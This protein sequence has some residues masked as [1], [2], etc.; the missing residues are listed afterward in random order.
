MFKFLFLMI[1]KF[2]KLKTLFAALDAST[3]LSHGE[4][5]WVGGTK[6]VVQGQMSSWT[7]LCRFSYPFEDSEIIREDS[8]SNSPTKIEYNSKVTKGYTG[9][10]RSNS[11]LSVVCRV[12]MW[13]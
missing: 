3:L 10:S 11:C 2:F 7:L 4:N 13:V 12:I 1:P 9:S 5:D 6:M 8:F